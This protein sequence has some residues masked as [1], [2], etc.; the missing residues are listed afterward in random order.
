M[1]LGRAAAEG[2]VL[3]AAH[4]DYSDDL[5]HS[6]AI[7]KLLQMKLQPFLEKILSGQGH[8]FSTTKAPAQTTLEE[9]DA[10]CCCIDFFVKHVFFYFFAFVVLLVKQISIYIVFHMRVSSSSSYRSS[11]SAS[12]R[13]NGAKATTTCSRWA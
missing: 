11:V 4:T 12:S 6:L 2:L 10:R 8:E 1:H 9:C 7:N 3:A 5:I 13:S